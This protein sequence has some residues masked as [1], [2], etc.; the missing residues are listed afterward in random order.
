MRKNVIISLLALMLVI[1][2]F[3]ATAETTEKSN[4][5][6]IQSDDVPIW[7]VGDS[8]TFFVSEFTVNYTYGDL[9]IVMDGQIDDFKWTVSDTS[10]SSYIVDITG[11]VSATF[12]CAFPIGDNVLNVNGDINPA[13]NKITGKIVLTKSNLEIEDFNAEIKGIAS[14][15]IEPLPIKLPL[16]I[17]ITADADLSTVFPLFNFPLHLLKFWN[18]PDLDIT[19]YTTFGGMFG[20]IKIPIT[21]YVSYAW[22]PLAFSILVQESITVPAGTYD[23]WRIQSLIGDYFVYY[24]AAEVGNLIKIDVNMP[25]GGIQA[26]LIDTN[27]S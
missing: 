14:V 2:S 4:P 17:K 3:I 15:Q 19:M 26:E 8:W 23:A 18:M 27:F 16:P 12:A 5:I 13:R 22:M 9:N 21:F 24:Y 10:G 6:I 25:S 1:P 11:K 20:I 7:E